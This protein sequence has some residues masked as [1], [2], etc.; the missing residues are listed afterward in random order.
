MERRRRSQGEA[1][2]RW[3]WRCK[4]TEMPPRSQPGSLVSQDRQ[5]EGVT[6]AREVNMVLGVGGVPT[7]GGQDGEQE[8][9]GQPS[10]REGS[11]AEVKVVWPEALR[12]GA[13]AP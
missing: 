7:E 11:T 4:Q 12:D 10:G 8:E 1:W 3:G 2:P 9:E 6:A 13:A 5:Q